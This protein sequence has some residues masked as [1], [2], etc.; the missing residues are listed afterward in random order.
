[1]NQAV[2]AMV[3]PGM[4]SAALDLGPLRIEELRSALFA[5][6][7]DGLDFVHYS[8]HGGRK[9]WSTETILHVDDTV[10]AGPAPPVVTAM[11]C[12]NGFFHHPSGQS[13]GEALLLDPSGGAVAYWGP[14]SLTS[15]LRQ[16]LLARAFYA[17]VF[18]A[19]EVTLGEA[20]QEAQRKVGADP[21]N[22]DLIETWVLLGDPGIRLR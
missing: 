20:I 16:Q 18:T 6:W 13:L 14:T 17:T 5:L 15:S 12:L 2:T 22:R 19:G 21:E 9:Q 11:N 4:T 3:P 1:M 8:G 10:A 7:A